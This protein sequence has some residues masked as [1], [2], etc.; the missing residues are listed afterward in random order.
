MCQGPVGFGGPLMS[1]GGAKGEAWGP[2]FG[3]VL[4]IGA[5]LAPLPPKGSGLVSCS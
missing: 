5:G 4:L 3:F 1:D 2:A